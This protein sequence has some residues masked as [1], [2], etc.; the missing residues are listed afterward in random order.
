MQDTVSARVAGEWLGVSER[1]IRD[2]AG[3]SI[4]SKTARGQYDL[5][6]VVRQ[7]AAHLREVAAGRG[8]TAQ[9]LDLT[10]ERARQAKEIADGQALK[11]AQARRELLPAAEVE[12][13]W[14]DICTRIRAA[15]LAVPARLRTPLNLSTDETALLD[16]ELR[17][18]LEALAD[19]NGDAPQG[20][21]E[22]EAAAED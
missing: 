9:V 2:L 10:A 4:I 5:Q 21:G 7:Y 18:T 13:Q 17:V 1:T 19:D 14:G 11:N 6:T 20:A 8:G 12:E 22:A 15:L 16:R 3:R